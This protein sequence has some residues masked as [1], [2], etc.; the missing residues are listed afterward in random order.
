MLNAGGTVTFGVGATIAVNSLAVSATKGIDI[1]NGGITTVGT[2]QYNNAVI[3]GANAVLTTTG[4]I[5]Y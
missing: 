1:N 2:Q 5:N 3:L 4:S